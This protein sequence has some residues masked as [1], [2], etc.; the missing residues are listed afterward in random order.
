MSVVETISLQEK[1]N[2]FAS[3]LRPEGKSTRFNVIEVANSL[4]ISV[5][6][7]TGAK[8]DSRQGVLIFRPKPR[9]EIYR[10]SASEINR[11]LEP[12]DEEFLTNTERFST[13]HEIG[14]WLLF[15]RCGIEPSVNRSGGKQEYWAQEE[16]VNSFA[17]QLLVPKWYILS[18]IS[19]LTRGQTIDPFVL[20]RWADDVS[21]SIEVLSKEICRF[22]SSFGM[23]IVTLILRRGDNRHALRVVEVCSGTDLKLPNRFKH[24]L[25]ERL[26]MTISSKK[27]GSTRLGACSL[28]E[29]EIQNFI[30]S[31]RELQYSQK[32][33]KEESEIDYRE[34]CRKWI[35]V[36]RKDNGSAT[37]KVLI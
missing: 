1:V 33:E 25:N 10:N 20:R 15:E 13:A 14:H 2:Q 3:E 23:M 8:F 26:R 31:W 7:K 30:I 28:D 36:F 9:I 29:R 35:I 5:S 27:F 12:E 37:K 34:E 4:G 18:R 19:E 24:I 16:L 6:I 11:L 21:V 32:N 17:G 22:Y